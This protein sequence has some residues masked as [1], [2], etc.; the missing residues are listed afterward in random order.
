MS[1]DV[2]PLMIH[3]ERIVRPVRAKASR[4]LRM[5]R[6]L[7]E[8]LKAAVEEEREQDAASGEIWE[9]AKRRLGEP[10]LLTE[11]LQ[12]TVPWLERV[13]LTKLPMPQGADGVGARSEKEWGFLTAAQGAAL[14]GI[15][16]VGTLIAMGLPVA[17]SDEQRNHFLHSGNGSG[18]LF[19]DL[20]GG[21]RDRDG[22]PLVVISMLGKALLSEWRTRAVLARAAVVVVLETLWVL[23]VTSQ[24]AAQNVGV[25]YSLCAVVLSVLMVAMQLLVARWVVRMGNHSR[26]WRML[27]IAE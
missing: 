20:H 8:H 11:Q 24:F 21:R 14:S 13:M 15:S 18:S 27:D 26:E 2:K 1:D 6:E 19:H 12:Q 10:A 3:V 25:G 17:M 22:V 16:M 9:R 4:K 5:R 23:L 7:L